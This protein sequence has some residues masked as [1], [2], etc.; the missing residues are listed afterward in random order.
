MLRI[1][2]KERS[3]LRSCPWE[4]VRGSPI[5]G[6]LSCLG[7]ISQRLNSPPSLPASTA[8]PLPPSLADIPWSGAGHA[9]QKS[10]CSP[11]Q[12][13]GQVE[14]TAARRNR[15]HQ[16][17]RH[18]GKLRQRLTARPQALPA[19]TTPNRQSTSDLLHSLR[20]PPHNILK[21]INIPTKS[22]KTQKIIGG[23]EYI[24]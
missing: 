10:K 17:E 14:A 8:V 15:P 19:S 2:L 4:Q 11:H 21:W 5:L 16:A 9:K 18:R 24:P 23:N 6:N 13:E 1:C 7:F 22:R 20:G 3:D 12:S